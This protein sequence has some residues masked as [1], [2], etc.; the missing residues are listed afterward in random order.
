MF[1]FK[2]N[3]FVFHKNNQ[4]KIN[5]EIQERSSGIFIVNAR[6]KDQKGHM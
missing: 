1:H 4:L 5:K 2:K 3:Q 6:K